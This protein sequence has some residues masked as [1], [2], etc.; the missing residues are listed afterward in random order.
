MFQVVSRVLTTQ[1]VMA[2]H[3]W[4]CFM[5]HHITPTLSRVLAPSMG[6][7]H[8]SRDT[9][10]TTP[11]L[12]HLRVS[13]LQSSNLCPESYKLTESNPQLNIRF[14]WYLKYSNVQ[15]HLPRFYLYYIYY[16]VIN[17]YYY[18]WLI[19]VFLCSHQC[20][21]R[22]ILPSRFNS[23]LKET[24]G[25]AETETVRLTAVWQSAPPWI[26]CVIAYSFVHNIHLNRFCF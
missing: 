11:T 10:S 1:E 6:L 16:S 3:L 20:Q 15:M 24:D 5:P 26:P 17:L 22:L 4:C 9:T 2:L 25:A 19:F 12:D 14:N 18:R 21:C 7:L 13:F 8:P 23:T